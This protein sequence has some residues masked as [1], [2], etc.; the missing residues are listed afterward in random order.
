MALLGKL[1]YWGGQGGVLFVWEAAFVASR[2]TFSAVV[3]SR[4]SSLL[5]QDSRLWN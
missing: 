5:Q 2:L 3:A 4:L 1:F